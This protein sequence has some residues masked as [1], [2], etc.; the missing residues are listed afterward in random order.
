MLDHALTY[1]HMG[2]K[3]FPVAHPTIDDNGNT[4]CS[5]GD[6]GCR[7]IGKHPILPGDW[8][9][10]ATADEDV[11]R[12][13]WLKYPQA[14]IAMRAENLVIL[15]VDDA[16]A[17]IE[18]P[19][20]DTVCSETGGGG[21]HYFFKTDKQYS[22]SPGNLPHGI[23][24]RGTNGYVVLPP[25]KHYSGRSYEWEVSSNPLDEGIEIQ[26]IP[27][28]LDLI[29]TAN[30]VRALENETEEVHLVQIDLE[31]AELEA[32]LETLPPAIRQLAKRKPIKEDDRSTK[33]QTLITAMLAAGWTDAEVYTAF[34]VLPYTDKF[35]E[36]GRNKEAYLSRSILNARRYLG[37]ERDKESTDLAYMAGYLDGW[38][39]GIHAATLTEFNINIGPIDPE[40]AANVLAAYGI[41]QK[42]DNTLVIPCTIGG[43]QINIMYL[44]DGKVSYE[45]MG[46]P[47][48]FSSAPEEPIEG[49]IIIVRRF[50]MAIMF[51][52]LSSKN[53]LAF[54]PKR[55]TEEGKVKEIL[56]RASSALIVGTEADVHM[57]EKLGKHVKIRR[58]VRLPNERILESYMRQNT[59]LFR[60]LYL[61]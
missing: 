40:M 22:N 18:L 58:S 54:S 56:S 36:K 51:S 47:A 15:D 31:D 10:Y 1:A 48:V 57:L 61:E 17:L 14:N 59:H 25:S 32:K 13:W 6:S 52:R 12:R 50:D 24:I 2:W 35:R 55:G 42:R 34:F 16:A 20:F 46:N 23:D 49:E 30:S 5:C 41:G 19:A 44:K 60:A 45:I 21:Y 37:Q 27:K 11:V 29:I 39:H 8:K 28:W 53:I 7:S 38:R 4:V 9:Q 43:E 3:I 33:E 26:P